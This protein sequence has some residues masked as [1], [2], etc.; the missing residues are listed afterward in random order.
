MD[1]NKC[2]AHEPAEEYLKDTEAGLHKRRQDRKRKGEMVD[3]QFAAVQ[4][5]A[6]AESNNLYVECDLPEHRKA[7]ALSSQ[8]KT[9][10]SFPIVDSL[11]LCMP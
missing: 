2:T 3:T 5:V 7:N 4:K 11:V 6:V 9:Q 10:I 8:L 1:N